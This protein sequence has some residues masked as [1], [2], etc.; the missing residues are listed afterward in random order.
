M[1]MVIA[2]VILSVSI[3]L[4]AIALV[5]LKFTIVFTVN[6]DYREIGIMKAIGMK[7]SALHYFLS[8]WRPSASSFLFFRYFDNQ[9][10]LPEQRAQYWPETEAECLFRHVLSPAF[11]SPGESEAG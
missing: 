8:V 3:C 4:I 7:T 10:A 9:P 11:A 1:E 5:M 6:E 2:A